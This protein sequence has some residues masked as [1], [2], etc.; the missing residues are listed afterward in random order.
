MRRALLIARREYVAYVRT[1]GFW[2]SLLIL[3]LVVG[4]SAAI[5]ILMKQ[6]DE[7]RA[8]AIADFSGREVGPALVAAFD[9]R[10]EEAQ[11]RELAQAAEAESG[12]AAA[13][14]VRA[15]IDR[16]GL[17]AGRAALARA[18]PKASAGL[19]PLARRVVVNPPPAP[20]AAAGSPDAAEAAARDYFKSLDKGDPGLDAIVI[21]QGDREQPRVSLWSRRVTDDVSVDA[22][23][24]AMGDVMR[25][26]AYQ[27]AGVDQA[28]V[29]AIEAA[30]PEVDVFSP[31]AASARGEVSMR[32]QIPVFV[33]L[34]A[35][36][37][38]WSL[39]MT[40][41]GILMN[42]VMEEK[43]NR[44]LEVLLSS[45]TTAEILS[46]KVLGVAGIAL[47]VLLVWGALALGVLNL[48]A[49]SW[50]TDLGPVFADGALWGV[51]ALYFIGG[52]LMY[53]VLFAA[54]GA[55]C[56]TPRDAQTLMGPIMIFLMVPLFV[57]QLA[58]RSPDLPVLRILSWVPFFT[59]FLMSARAP[60]DPP[61]MEVGGTL[62]AMA[63]VAA[64][65]MW[66]GGRAFRAGALSTGK[67]EWKALLSA[68]R[69]GA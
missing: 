45:A 46:G 47:T 37:L 63:V 64:A 57:M 13:E 20:V 14:T 26:A 58:L 44:V 33:G 9:R 22:V 4:M 69:R 56:E 52:Y 60:T 30:E 18:A 11:A 53:G 35:G 66:L 41:A 27:A 50:L 28:R 29:R 40:A 15:E 59:P 21:L 61:A 67:L 68:L 62:L 23:R 49:P 32:D 36:F 42:S 39:I 16:G 31:E 55:F 25:A 34:G 10:F 38:L 51:I 19:K 17:A 8:V 5:P 3:P 54:I 7:S 65:L 43:S 1:V 24:D 6:A 12:P 48:M 2:L